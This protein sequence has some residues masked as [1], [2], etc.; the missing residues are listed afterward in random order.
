MEAIDDSLDYELEHNFTQL[1]YAISGTRAR[2]G[3]Q[4]TLAIT[5]NSEVLEKLPVAMRNGFTAENVKELQELNAF[6][7]SNAVPSDYIGEVFEAV[8][9]VIDV[10][11]DT[12]P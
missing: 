11:P 12:T 3:Q 9:V 2:D 4:F 5:R 8:T 10:L 1:G 6:D 7:F